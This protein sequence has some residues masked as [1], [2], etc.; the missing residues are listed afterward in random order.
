MGDAM[1][2]EQ[3]AARS[4]YIGSYACGCA[5]AAVV[6]DPQF[7]KD[8]AKRIAEWVRNGMTVERLTCAATK[9]SAWPCPGKPDCC[10]KRMRKHHGL[11]KPSSPLLDLPS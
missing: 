9:L 11:D 3:A 4:C 2:N 5:V 1:T 7:K 10:S 8:T 6:D